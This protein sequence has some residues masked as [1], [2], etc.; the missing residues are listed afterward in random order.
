MKNQTEVLNSLYP[1]GKTTLMQHLQTLVLRN[2]S[3]WVGGAIAPAKLEGLVLKMADR[4]PLDRDE[5][6]R[7]YDRSKGLATVHLVVYPSG[8][9]VLWWLLSSEGKG[10]LADP[11]SLDAKV[12]KQ[13][14]AADGH[15]EFED[16]VMLYAHKKDARTLTDAKTGKEKRVI[17]DASTWTWKL[18][19]TSVSEL[20]AQLAKEVATLNYGDDMTSKPY[21]VRGFLGYQRRRPLFSGVRAQVLDLHREGLDL[22]GGVRKQWL[23]RNA[24]YVQQYGDQAGQLRPL[25]EVLTKHLPKMGRF[26]VFADPAR[27]VKSLTE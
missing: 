8:G 19:P 14:M 12:G 4:Y 17:K 27:T 2:N 18:R 25:K 11:A 15:I 5:R 1:S 22:W 26:K 23:G 10:G 21:G 6:G 3:Y 24:K 13:A 20:R 16:Y 9:K 7:T